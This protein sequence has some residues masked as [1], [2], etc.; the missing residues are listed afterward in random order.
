MRQIEETMDLVLESAKTEF[1]KKGYEKAKLRSIAESAGV[2]TGAIYVRFPNKDALFS[3]LVSSVADHIMSLLREGNRKGV[4]RLAH[5]ASGDLWA[6]YN[7]TVKELIEYIYQNK[8]TLALLINCSSGS[9][10]EYFV[11]KI[12]GEE[13]IQVLKLLDEIKS[14]GFSVRD[15]DPKD[16]HILLSAQYYTLFEVVRHK[17]EKKEAEQKIQLM[18]DFFRAGWEKVISI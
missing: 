11:E 5:G 14:K 12:I 1:L 15:I 13:E 16:I 10:Y 8:E 9:S 18:A 17:M 3:A 6:I 7:D 2:T 4:D